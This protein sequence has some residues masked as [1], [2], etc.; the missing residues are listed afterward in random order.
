MV[1]TWT[2]YAA[3]LLDL[4]FHELLLTID[5]DLAEACRAEGC[6][7]CGGRLHSARFPRKPN[8]RQKAV[9]CRLGCDHDLRFSLC[10]AAAECRLRETPPTVRLHAHPAI[11]PQ[12]H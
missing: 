4:Q 10:C 9:A 3:V 7:H 12:A 11:D 2:M 1:T 5:R 8:G 6:E